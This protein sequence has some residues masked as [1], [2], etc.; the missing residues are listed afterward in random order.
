MGGGE[1]FTHPNF[2]EIINGL[3]D[4]G[5]R[6]SIIS[7][8]S[9]PINKLNKF[10]KMTEG[11]LDYFVASLHLEQAQLQVFIK[12]IITIKKR[13]PKFKR[14]FVNTVAKKEKMEEAKF[15]KKIFS[16]KKI[17]L[18]FLRLKKPSPDKEFKEISYSPE[19]TKIFSFPS[20]FYSSPKLTGKL[21]SSGQKSAIIDPT[22]NI[23]R[24]IS[25]SNTKQGYLG[26]LLTDDIIFYKK[27]KPCQERFCF[28]EDCYVTYKRLTT[29]PM[30]S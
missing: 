21:C 4:S 18:T 24:C 2:F 16:A 7:N 10:F 1:P 30:R 29:L 19:E 12:K 20:C 17:R 6:L 15:L 27:P 11:N 26:N 25:G 23:F 28:C 13:F 8:F 22:G 9:A 14:F 5:Y 3:V